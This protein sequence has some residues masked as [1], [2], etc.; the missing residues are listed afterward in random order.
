[1]VRE[2]SHEPPHQRDRLFRVSGVEVHLAAAR[3]LE[4]KVNRDA[5][6]FEQPDHGLSG[7]RKQGVVEAGD[8]ERD[9]WRRAGGRRQ[10]QLALAQRPAGATTGFPCCASWIGGTSGSSRN[11]RLISKA[12]AVRRRIGGS[13]ARRAVE[14]TRPAA[15][16]T[17]ER[18]RPGRAV[19]PRAPRTQTAAATKQPVWRPLMNAWLT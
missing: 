16:G 1:M 7:A 13:Q 4:R 15:I 3:L 8:E 11:R 5:E 14:A 18:R 9:A 10:P 12:C 6:A 17:L 2:H 19:A